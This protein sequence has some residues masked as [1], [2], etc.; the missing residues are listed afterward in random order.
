MLNR[1]RTVQQLC[2]EQ[3]IDVTQLAERSRVDE[4]RVQAIIDGRWTPSPADRDRIAEAL[5]LTRDQII[6]DHKI[7]V[8]HLYGQGPG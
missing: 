2:I 8:Q 6:W 4:Q 7:P 3:G 5:G 1:L